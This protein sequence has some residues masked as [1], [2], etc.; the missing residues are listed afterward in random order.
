M[1]TIGQV[2]T[3]HT[4][5]GSRRHPA[6]RVAACIV[7]GVIG[8]LGTLG[9]LLALFL[10]NLSF[11]AERPHVPVTHTVLL[12]AGAA[13]GIGVPALVSALVLNT[14]RQRLVVAAV[15]LTVLL[16]GVLSVVGLL[17]V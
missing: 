16:L 11:F 1:D 17:G 15:I 9:C 10:A 13:A 2:S 14:W 12:L 8:A 7:L 4:T 6:L 5:P 3:H